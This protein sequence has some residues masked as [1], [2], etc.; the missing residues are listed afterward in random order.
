M[1]LINLT[2]IFEMTVRTI[3]VN[4]LAIFSVRNCIFRCLV[5]FISL[6]PNVPAVSVQQPKDG[7][8]VLKDRAEEIGVGFFCY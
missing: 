6:Q 8:E 1:I 5:C 4:G 7:M 2:F 3:N